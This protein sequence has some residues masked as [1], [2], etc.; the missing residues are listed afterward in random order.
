MWTEKITRLFQIPN[1]RHT[2]RLDLLNAKQI[3]CIFK[4]ENI[5]PSLVLEFP[6]WWNQPYVYETT[7]Q[8]MW[9]GLCEQCYEPFLRLDT[10][11]DMLVCQHC[12]KEH[13]PPERDFFSLASRHQ[14]VAR[15]P[16]SVNQYKRSVFFK[17]WLKRLQGKEFN[18]V[19]RENIEDVR[20]LLKKEGIR[21]LHYLAVKK[22]MRQLGLTHLYRHTTYI[23]MN[24]RGVPLVHLT[25]NQETI[26]IKL[27]MEIQ[28]VFYDLPHCRVNMLSYPYL[29]KKFCELKHWTAMARVIPILKSYGR[30]VAMD[31]IWK[32]ICRLKKWTF[33]ATTQYSYLD[34]RQEAQTKPSTGHA[35]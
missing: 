34:D 25:P 20:S 31:F 26:L 13:I 29:I 14:V 30:V 24:L 1:Y 32:E 21:G 23:M 9:T 8:K 33:T 17:L 7:E 35:P 15:K 2:K 5:V 16:S 28:Q 27:F 4:E 19:T 12:G 10:R 22:A 3:P 11:L 6:V 18:H